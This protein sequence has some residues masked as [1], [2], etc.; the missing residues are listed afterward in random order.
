MTPNLS[1][2]DTLEILGYVFSFVF[3]LWPLVIVSPLRGRKHF[4][5]NM[6][7]MWIILAAMRAFLFFKPGLSFL[8]LIPEPFNTVLFCMTGIVLWGVKIVKN[9][10]NQNSLRR[11]GDGAS[12]PSDLLSLSAGEFE[13]MIV[14]YY[15]AAGHE[16]RR[17]G[18]T[19]DH[20]VDVI[21][22]AKNGEKWV[23]QCK[24]WRGSVG[25]PVI[26]DL[27]G[28]IQ[29]EKADRGAVITTGQFTEQAREWAR[30][31]PIVLCNGKQFLKAWRR[32]RQG[33]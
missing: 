2:L 33:G 27:H 5:A 7:V 17:T 18:N 16:A 12:K 6:L 20:G 24:R 26:R 1:P 8:V 22:Q 29:H 23:V 4:L 21:V 11:T 25:E 10:S 13:E 19:G 9:L 14:E 30:G 3:I 31:K 28:V 32:V 15:R